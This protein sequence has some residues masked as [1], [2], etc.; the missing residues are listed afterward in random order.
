MIISR[1]IFYQYEPENIDIG[2]R[3]RSHFL[4]G[5]VFIYAELPERQVV[6]GCFRSVGGAVV[7]VCV[8]GGDDEYDTHR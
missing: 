3:I 4:I 2:G 6:F 1:H 8:E 7:V 5:V